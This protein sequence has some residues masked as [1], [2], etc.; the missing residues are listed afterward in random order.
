MKYHGREINTITEFDTDEQSLI[1]NNAINGK[2]DY[3]FT[4]K[5]PI[6]KVSFDKVIS[7]STGYTNKDDDTNY[8]ILNAEDAI[9]LGQRLIKSATIA[10]MQQSS[11]SNVY[12]LFNIIRDIADKGYLAK[13]VYKFKRMHEY[14]KNY[15]IFEVKCVPYSTIQDEHLKEK[16]KSYDFEFIIDLYDVC[17]YE[18]LEKIAIAITNIANDKTKITVLSNEELLS[19]FRLQQ[20]EQRKRLDDMINP[21]NPDT[22][23]IPISQNK[24]EIENALKDIVNKNK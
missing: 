15:A 16:I 9:E 20:E 10:L 24:D 19:Q 14:I 12:R 13:V 23:A 4:I 8:F 18:E 5:N 22:V 3:K 7:L 11:D 21:D 1:F 17:S 6:Q 2:K